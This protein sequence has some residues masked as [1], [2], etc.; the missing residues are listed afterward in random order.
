[1]GQEVEETTKGK[2]FGHMWYRRVYV[3]REQL[4]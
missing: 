1:M 4:H 2:V 3:G